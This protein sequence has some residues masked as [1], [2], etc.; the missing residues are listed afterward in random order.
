MEVYGGKYSSPDKKTY[1][2]VLVGEA[3]GRLGQVNKGYP[4][5][6]SQ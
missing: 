6:L 2:Y 5:L 1:K 3:A 4:E